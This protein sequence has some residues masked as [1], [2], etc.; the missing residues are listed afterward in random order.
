MA[1]EHDQRRLADI[2]VTDVVS[3]SRL[4]G[5]DEQGTLAVLMVHRTELIE[6]CPT[7]PTSKSGSGPR[8][9]SGR[10]RES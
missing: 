6:P 1:E 8:A 10:R 9:R 2:L 7:E 4:M 3:Y 5:D